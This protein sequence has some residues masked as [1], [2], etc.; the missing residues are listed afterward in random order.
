MEQ[1]LTEGDGR[2]AL[3]DHVLDRAHTARAKYG[4]T[5]DADAILKILDDRDLVRYPVGTRFDASALDAGQFAHA[6]PLGDHPSQGFC[7][8][9]HPS[10]ESRRDLWPLLI[11]YHIPPINYGDIT[12][13]E[14]CEVFG[15]VLLGLSQDEYYQALCVLTDSIR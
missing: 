12:E 8:F 13:A 1:R 5:I 2:R 6:Q 4:P 15:A 3:R 7:L 9:I 10:F 11:A 14:D